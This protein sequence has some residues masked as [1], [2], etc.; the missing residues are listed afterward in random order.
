[1]QTYFNQIRSDEGREVRDAIA[2]V[3]AS[4]QQQSDVPAYYLQ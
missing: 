3:R 4:R 1:M 2:S